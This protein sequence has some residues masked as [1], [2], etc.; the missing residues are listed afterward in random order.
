MAN[1]SQEE[2]ER[3]STEDTASGQS[4]QTFTRR[5]ESAACVIRLYRTAVS[6]QAHAIL[7][8]NVPEWR[9]FYR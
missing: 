4:P 9:A 1:D 6:L 8:R 7:E 5:G 2:G 3:G